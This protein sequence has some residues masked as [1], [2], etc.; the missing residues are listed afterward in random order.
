MISRQ[1]NGVALAPPAWNLC[2]VASDLAAEQSVGGRVFYTTTTGFRANT[3]L[4]LF[5]NHPPLFVAGEIALGLSL[6]LFVGALI[7]A[8]I[9]GVPGSL[10]CA[11]LA[12]QIQRLFVGLW[13]KRCT[14]IPMF[15]GRLWQRR[16]WFDPGRGPRADKASSVEPTRSPRRAL[17][18]R[19][20]PDKPSTSRGNHL[21]VLL[22]GRAEAVL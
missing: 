2:E 21:R 6:A 4:A 19:K 13:T 22:F 18:P 1:R 5:L 11:N 16:R 15:R 10:S 20:L 3:M 7:A 12:I 17:S 14:V 9:R 8:V